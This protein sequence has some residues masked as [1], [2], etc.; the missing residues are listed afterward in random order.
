MCVADA[1][2]KLVGYQNFF[3]IRLSLSLSLQ[4]VQKLYWPTPSRHPVFQVPSTDGHPRATHQSQPAN[5]KVVGHSVLAL[6]QVLLSL[7]LKGKRFLGS[8][9]GESINI[10]E[11]LATIVTLSHTDQTVVFPSLLPLSGA[12][13]TFKEGFHVLRFGSFKISALLAPRM[14]IGR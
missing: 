8:N 3:I 7:G 6:L 13:D 11:I 14:Q 1:R 10:V 5:R 9:H 4:V 2:D 12:D